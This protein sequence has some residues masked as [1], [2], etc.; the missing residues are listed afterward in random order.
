[1]WDIFSTR[2]S[3]MVNKFILFSLKERNLKDKEGERTVE[4]NEDVQNQLHAAHY[5]SKKN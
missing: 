4:V 1:M 5:F 2:D 3:N